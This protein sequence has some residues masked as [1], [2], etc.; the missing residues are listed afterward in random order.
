MVVLDADYAGEVRR[1]LDQDAR[2]AA[3]RTILLRVARRRRTIDAA[4]LLAGAEGDADADGRHD[5]LRETVVLDVG[6][7]HR[8]RLPSIVDPLVIT[9]VPTLLW[10]PHG[11]LDAVR[12]LAPLAQTVLFD[13]DDVATAGGSDEGLE[14]ARGLHETGLSVVDLAW[15][16]TRPFR[17][18]LAGAYDPPAGRRAQRAIAEVVVS[19]RSDTATAARL[20]TGWL[21]SRLRWSTDDEGTVRDAAGEAVEVRLEPTDAE[22]RGIQGVTVTGRD[23]AILGLDRARG[24]LRS[25]LARP[26]EPERAWTVLGASRGERGLLAAA[27]RRSLL[28]DEGYDAAL[29][30][31]ATMPR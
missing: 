31:A 1:R 21:S 15:L 12:S 5:P 29:R 8:D 22:V 20:L 14:V 27:L 7:H 19:H 10:A 23:G 4:V 11:D 6:D 16:R 28:S 26:G 17:L 30:A 2:N 24:G 18:R 3:S 13:G 9:D 25:T